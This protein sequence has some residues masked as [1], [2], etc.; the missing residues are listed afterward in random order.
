MNQVVDLINGN[1][2]FGLEQPPVQLDNKLGASLPLPFAGDVCF[3][4]APPDASL[5]IL[6]GAVLLH[7]NHP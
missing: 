7:A 5:C 1:V 3:F 4:C 2:K 6:V